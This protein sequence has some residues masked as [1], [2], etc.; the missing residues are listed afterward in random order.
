MPVFYMKVAPKDFNALP[1]GEVPAK[2]KASLR[3]DI[4]PNLI[5]QTQPKP[6]PNPT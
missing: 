4:Y 2:G 1:N 6:D 3:L 5:T